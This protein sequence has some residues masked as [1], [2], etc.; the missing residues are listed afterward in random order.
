[1]CCA[2]KTLGQNPKTNVL[3][4]QNAGGCGDL[5]LATREDCASVS[6]C[7]EE[8]ALLLPS[9]YGLGVD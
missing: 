8:I 9:P 4:W 2:A 1:M 6:A 5:I 3:H 7:D